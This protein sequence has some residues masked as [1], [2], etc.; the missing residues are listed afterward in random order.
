MDRQKA[1]FNRGPFFSIHIKLLPDTPNLLLRLR[2]ITA[3]KQICMTNYLMRS[4]NHRLK[5]F[6]YGLLILLAMQSPVW[7]S[8]ARAPFEKGVAAFRSEDYVTALQYFEQ[9]RS[10]GFEDISLY[11]NLGVTNYKLGH[12][13]EA[14]S[15]FLKLINDP[16]MA[17]LAS[18]NLGLVA[19]KRE[20]Y[21]RAE[22][23]FRKT[24]TI[25][26]SDKLAKLS[27]EQLR[28][29]GYDVPVQEEKVVYPG[30]AM[31]RGSLGYDDNVILQADVLTSSTANQDDSFFEFFAFGNK[32]VAQLG[33]KALQIEASLFNIRYSELSAYNLDDLYLG[34][35]LEGK[36]GQWKL[37]TGLSQDVTFVGGNGLNSTATLQLVGARKFSENNEMRLRYRLSRIDAIDKAYAYLAGWRHQAQLDST[38]RL[39]WQQIRFTYRFEY[40][41]R[42]DLQVPHF[43]SYS[44]TRHILGIR[45]IFPITSRLKASI[46]LRYRYSHFHDASK[47]FNGSF[48]TRS[49]KRY[50]VTARAIYSLSSHTDLT[51]EYTYTD[52]L[53]NLPIEQYTRNQYQLNLSYLW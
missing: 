13:S 16:K 10:E 29:L 49:D 17:P 3:I 38:L 12:F 40:N 30:F 11:Y 9:A 46:D 23:W 43:T 53:S 24:L 15:A 32:Q 1:P 37:D 51:G 4:L 44:P 7:G 52:N 27:A 26:K 33:N 48:I 5:F 45:D 36:L 47:Q 50:R 14:E 21:K 31:V 34:V 25:S 6:I 41:D 2:G 18:Y 42:K 28:R 35:I 39:G 22:E 19:L 8:P 20:N